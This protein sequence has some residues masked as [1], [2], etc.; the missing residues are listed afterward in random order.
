[1]SSVVAVT[2]ATGQVGRSLVGLLRQKGVAVRAI[3]RSA[4][5]LRAATDAGAE[6]RVGSQDDL[7]FL[8][9]AFEGAT[10]VFVMI[11]PDYTA[12]DQRAYQRR[13]GD[14]LA[15]ALAAAKVPRA[16]ALSSLGGELSEGN[17]PIAGLHDFEQRLNAVS[18]LHVLYLRPAYFMENHL[19]GVGLIKGQ[20]IYGS[21]IKADVAFPMIATRDIAAA[22]AEALASSSFTG[23]SVRELLG[24]RDYTMRETARI[25]GQ[26]IGRPDVPYVEF[27]YDATRDALVGMGFSADAARLFVEMYDGFNAGRIHPLQG[28]SASTTTPTT[29]EQFAKDT[30]AP[31]YAR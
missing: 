30:F 4:D 16:V 21:P 6:A 27:P 5:R 11:P 17:G 12:A 31:A 22:A 18:G 2:G 15:E 20:G 8:T 1:M 14:R 10:A 3:G 7:S 26:A 24:P 25:L 13:L 23:Q 29:L 19:H 28:R 9:K